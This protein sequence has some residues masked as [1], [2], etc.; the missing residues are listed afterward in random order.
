MPRRSA[1]L[2]VGAAPLVRPL[3]H[4]LGAKPERRAQPIW[5]PEING[6]ASLASHPAA[7]PQQNAQNDFLG[8]A[9]SSFSLPAKTAA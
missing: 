9:S 1:S 2:M 7:K 6:E 3:A 5:N 8:K 4:K